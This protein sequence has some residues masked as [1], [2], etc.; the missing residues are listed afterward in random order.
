MNKNKIIGL[1]IFLVT[2]LVPFNLGLLQ[3]LEPDAFTLTMF[4]FTIV[5]IALGGYFFSKSNKGAD[6]S[7]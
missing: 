5:G 2:A 6:Q 4:L 1:V 3:R 7:A